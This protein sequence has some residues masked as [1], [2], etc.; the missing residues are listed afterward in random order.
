MNFRTQIT[1]AIQKQLDIN[2]ANKIQLPCTG[3]YK[4]C[5]ALHFDVLGVVSRS[6]YVSQQQKAVIRKSKVGMEVEISSQTLE[7]KLNSY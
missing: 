6:T 2:I 3:R 4:S 5:H 1:N 7:T